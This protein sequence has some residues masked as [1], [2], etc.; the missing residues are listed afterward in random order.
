MLATDASMMLLRIVHIGAVFTVVAEAF[1][2]AQTLG[3]DEAVL[4]G[5]D[6]RSRLRRGSV[7]LAG[8]AMA[9]ARY[10]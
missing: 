2:E 6:L 5:G 3:D 4:Q 10:V 8:V 1:R 7:L 9:S